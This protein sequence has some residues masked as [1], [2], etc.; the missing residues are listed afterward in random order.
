MVYHSSWYN[1][2]RDS[3]GETEGWRFWGIISGDELGVE[4]AFGKF[5]QDRVARGNW[6]WK[7][8]S[9]K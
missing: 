3:K 2:G 8:Q 6:Q 5:S 7:K 9:E 1:L 4:T